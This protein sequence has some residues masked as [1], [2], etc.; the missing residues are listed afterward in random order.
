MYKAIE[1][2]DEARDWAERTLTTHENA[3]SD[4]DFV[5]ACSERRL[6]YETGSSRKQYFGCHLLIR[7]DGTTGLFMHGTH[8]I[9]D[10][11]GGLSLFHRLF[12]AIVHGG[13]A[14][15][16]MDSLLG[17]DVANLPPDLVHVIGEPFRKASERMGVVYTKMIK[18]SKVRCYVCLDHALLLTARYARSDR[19]R[20]APSAR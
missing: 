1:N 15:L 19:H 4:E 20:A 11:R 9:L 10:I 16:D 8:A 6:P 2:I 5:A 13:E 17:T 12:E 7:E 14:S 3:P 18:G